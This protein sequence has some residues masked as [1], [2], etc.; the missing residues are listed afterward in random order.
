M[1]S[2]TAT[3]SRLR[4]PKEPDMREILSMPSAFWQRMLWAKPI[5]GHPGYTHGDGGCNQ[6][7]IPSFKI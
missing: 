1:N 4:H 6:F 3:A 2:T 5:P 7:F